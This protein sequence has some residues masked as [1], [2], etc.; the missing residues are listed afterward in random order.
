MPNTPDISIVQPAQLRWRNG[1]PYSAQGHDVYFCQEN[2]LAESQY[3]FL[4]QNDLPA[5]WQAATTFTILETGFGTGLNYLATAQCWLQ[6]TQPHQQLHYIALERFPLS[7][8]ELAQVWQHW[9][10]LAAL[11]QPLLTQYPPCI[12]GRYRCWLQPP[13]IKLT[14]IWGDANTELPD[15]YPLQADAW[16]LDGFNPAHN[17]D[18]WQ[19]ALFRAVSQCLKPG[20]TFA[21]FS[22]AGQVRRDLQN[23]GFYCEKIKGFGYKRE[24][25]RGYWPGHAAH[26][27]PSQQPSPLKKE[28][29]ILIIGAGIAGASCAQQFAQQGYAVT[30]LEQA[31]HPAQGASGNPAGVIMPVFTA[32]NSPYGQFYTR[33]YLHALQAL[34]FHPAWHPTGVLQLP[35]NARQ[36]RRQ[37]LIFERYQATGLVQYWDAAAISAW[38]GE[39][40]TQAGLFYPQAGWVNPVAWCQTLLAHPLI[41]FYPDQTVETLAT[42]G[43]TW[44]ARTATGLLFAAETIILATAHATAPLIPQHRLPLILARGQISQ[45]QASALPVQQA[46]R[47]ER[48]YLIPYTDSTYWVGATYQRHDTDATCRTSDHALNYAQ[49]AK[50]WP[51]F[52]ASLLGPI[53]GRVGFR[54]ATPDRLPLIGALQPGLWVSVGHGA[55]GLMS[56]GLAAELLMTEI[57][58]E[59]PLLPP[60]VIAAVDPQRFF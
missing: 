5:R 56:A 30:V 45:F 4:K 35:H 28:K 21:T 46:V 31:A 42:S 60:A 1:Q 47:C 59:L 37:R 2:G 22:A 57:N 8:A 55:R 3:L 53:H 50:S 39:N 17:P 15:L 52:A 9:P 51:R 58:G 34:Q 25:L 16:Y 11:G 27:A 18:L 20:A 29:S 19:P 23:A 48:H 41:Q 36:Q 24:S 14:L 40:I 38:C 49:L 7:A 12:A 26:L 10:A 43:H 13:R 44:Q 6:T 33:C 32:D 54:A